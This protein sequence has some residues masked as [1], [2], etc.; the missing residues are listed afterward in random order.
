VTE[1]RG[2]G[3]QW[4]RPGVTPGDRGLGLSRQGSGS[5]TIGGPGG[6][7]GPMVGGGLAGQ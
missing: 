5:P 4:R 3:D 1:G 6:G 7:G 2:S